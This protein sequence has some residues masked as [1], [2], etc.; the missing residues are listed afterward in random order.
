MLR[1]RPM[2]GK[3]SK[4][5][6]NGK[7]NKSAANN[8]LPLVSHRTPHKISGS[9]PRIRSMLALVETAPRELIAG[10]LARSAVVWHIDRYLYCPKNPGD[11][12]KCRGYDCSI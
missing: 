2:R 3:K 8:V 4:S 6:K 11:F 9:R 1:K 12:Y 10:E 7:S 5:R